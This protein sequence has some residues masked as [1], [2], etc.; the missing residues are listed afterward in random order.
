MEKLPSERI[1]AEAALSHPWI[2]EKVRVRMLA[3][4]SSPYPLIKAEEK[5][6]YEELLSK[7]KEKTEIVTETEFKFQPKL[8]LKQ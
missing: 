1:T 2:L 6:R 3:N 7:L 5:L 4:K 8:S